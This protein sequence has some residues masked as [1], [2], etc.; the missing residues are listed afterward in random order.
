MIYA[1]LTEAPQKW[2]HILPSAAQQEAPIL[3]CIISY[4]NV[5]Y[6]NKIILI[7]FFCCEV[8]YP[9][10]LIKN[11]NF[12]EKIFWDYVNIQFL[13]KLTLSVLDSL[14]IQT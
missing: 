5:Y 12:Y 13:I 1:F 11:S 10:C 6:M 9:V 8:N 7:K 2:W 14:I 4:I 3:I